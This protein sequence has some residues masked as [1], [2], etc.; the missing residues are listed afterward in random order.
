MEMQ[1]A[2]AEAIITR[3]MGV[4]LNI[5]TPRQAAAPIKNITRG[6]GAVPIQVHPTQVRTHQEPARIAMAPAT[7][8]I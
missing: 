3:T 2:I 6:H 7:T 4:S 1:A 5:P 8:T